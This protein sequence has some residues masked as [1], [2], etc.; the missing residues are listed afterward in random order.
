[1]QAIHIHMAIT[2]I[3]Q[4]LAIC[5][6]RSMDQR[7]EESQMCLTGKMLGENVA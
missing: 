4:L 2:N 1:M 3:A 7:G 5:I 6:G